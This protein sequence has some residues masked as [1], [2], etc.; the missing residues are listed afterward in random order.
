MLFD[1]LNWSV[2]TS[3]SVGTAPWAKDLPQEE[4][5]AQQVRAVFEV[6]VAHDPRY[7]TRIDGNWGWARK[8]DGNGNAGV[9]RSLSDR[10]ADLARSA[11]RRLKQLT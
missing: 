4:R 8:S 1:D 6:L 7:K 11:R 5:D 2:A 3:P 9:S 10:S